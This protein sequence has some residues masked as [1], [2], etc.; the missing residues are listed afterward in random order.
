MI[1]VLEG[2]RRARRLGRDVHRRAHRRRSPSC[3]R[4]LRARSLG[5]D[6][7]R[8]PGLP[9]DEIERFAD[10]VRRAPRRA[11][12]LY[13][14]GLTQY[15]FGV[16]NVKMVVNLALARG[17]LGREKYGIIPIRGHSRRAGHRRVRRR[18][19]QAARAASRSPTR[20]ARSFE[21]AWGHPIP[22]E[23]GL[24]GGARCSTR[25]ARRRDRRCSTSSAATS[26][27]P[28]PIRTTRG[29]ALARVRAAHPPGHRA[30][31]LDA[32]R[33][34]GA[35]AR[36]AG[37]DALRAAGGT[38]TSTERRIRFSPAIDD[39]DGG[40]I[41]EARA[42]WEIPALIGRALRPDQP[43]LFP[44][45][46]APPTCAPRWA[47]SMPLYAG[48]EGLAAGG[49]VGAVGRRAPG[50]RR[51][52]QHARR[53]RALLDGARSRRPTLPAGKFLLDHAARQ[54]VQLDH[55]RA[56]GSDHRRRRG[57]TSCCSTPTTSPRC[58]LADGERV[59]LRS[60]RSARWRRPRARGPCRRAP[61][62]G[63]LARVPTC[64]SRARYDPVSGEPDYNAVVSVERAGATGSRTSAA[65][66]PPPAARPG[67]AAAPS[68]TRASSGRP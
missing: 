52:S 35:G 30:Q 34:R 16:D 20:A 62:A 6:R 3:A 18:R 39:P 12:L 4:T 8:E 59:V 64:C 56:E 11:V 36:A 32:G 46:D 51:L 65:A 2:A 67:A 19:R 42:E 58:G 10:A 66:S 49:A 54:A 13:S 21:A 43:Q 37:A 45:A 57:A 17:K 24:Q 40:S 27:R 33:R 50:R 14:M 7:R 15:T 25:R 23:Q 5:R 53:A 48:I 63:V 38:S 1:G 22:R 61:R 9:R 68:P 44:C 31:H 47:R 29:A 60:R 41:A 26:S 55:L 28:C